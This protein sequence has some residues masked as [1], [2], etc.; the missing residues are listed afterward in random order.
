MAAAGRLARGCP[1]EAR[2]CRLRLASWAPAATSVLLRASAGRHLQHLWTFRT[3][4]LF[5]FPLQFPFTQR[6]SPKHFLFIAAGAK[7]LLF[8]NDAVVAE[9]AKAGSANS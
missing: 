5:L 7:L 3:F 9:K 4:L 1:W 6:L 2:D 8:C